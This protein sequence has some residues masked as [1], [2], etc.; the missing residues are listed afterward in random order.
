MALHPLAVQPAVKTICFIRR[1]EVVNLGNVPPGRTVLERLRE[2]FDCTG[3][4]EGCGEG[5]CGACTVVHGQVEAGAFRQRAVN[6]CT[7]RKKRCCSAMRRN[8]A[9]ARRVLSWAC[10]AGATAILPPR[11]P[12]R[13][14]CCPP[15]AVPVARRSRFRSPCW[16]RR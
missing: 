1:G 12:L 8:P 16:W 4:E 15:G 10:L 2:D 7:R 13:V 3:T 5:D 9:F 11:L 14:L 6:S